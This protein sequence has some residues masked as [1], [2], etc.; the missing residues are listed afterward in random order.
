MAGETDKEDYTDMKLELEYEWQLDI[1]IREHT[2]KDP[3][4]Q[5][6]SSSSLKKRPISPYYRFKV[7]DEERLKRKE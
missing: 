7:I 5:Q 4:S 2:K 3:G 1:E 6:K